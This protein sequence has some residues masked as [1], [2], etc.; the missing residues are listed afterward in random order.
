MSDALMEHLADL[1]ESESALWN[2]DADLAHAE[3]FE[4]AEIE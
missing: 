2:D 3:F 4:D 1:A